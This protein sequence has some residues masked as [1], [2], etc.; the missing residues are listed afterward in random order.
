MGSN[1]TEAVHCQPVN[2][3]LKISMTTQSNL[4]E[5]LAGQRDA[6][7][8]M[9][10]FA[11]QQY[12]QLGMAVLDSNFRDQRKSFADAVRCYEAIITTRR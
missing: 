5:S 12:T 11:V 4:D 3:A 10:S 7:H 6:K 1:F 9:W 2:F 8:S